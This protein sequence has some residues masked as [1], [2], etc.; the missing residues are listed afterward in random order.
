MKK[1][2][3]IV[4][5]LFC[6][7]FYSMQSNYIPHDSIS[8]D[9]A[10][11][12][13]LVTME[14]KGLGDHSGKCLELSLT[15]NTSGSLNIIVNAG[16]VFNPE[17]TDMQD[18]FVVKDQMVV[19]PQK[20]MTKHQI[21]GYCCQMSDRSP[22][23]GVAFTKG[24]VKD[25]K[26]IT[27]AN[28]INQNKYPE[29]V[30]QNAVWCVSDNNSIADIY[31]ENE[32]DM[33]QVKALREELSKITGQKNVWYNNATN[34]SVNEQGYINREP[35][36]VSGALTMTIDKPVSFRTEIRHEDNS[37]YI[38]M[39]RETRIDR[40]GKFDYDFTLKVRGWEKGKYFVVILAGEKEILKQEFEV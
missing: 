22:S 20:R 27:L 12:K 2:L 26:L 34:V 5:M 35:V 4:L 38:K 39:D 33:N 16:S 24:T 32:E 3:A 15:N 29:S 11:K 30:F 23:E 19:L 17:Q 37:V 7:M 18:I 21:S 1:N 25:Q 8:L 28:H 9:E 10:I 36:M 6:G 31:A 40:I 13:G 14:A